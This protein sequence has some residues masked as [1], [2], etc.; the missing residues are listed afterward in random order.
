MM[1]RRP[2]DQRPNFAAETRSRP[3]SGL[4]PL[5]CAP[6]TNSP[7]GVPHEAQTALRPGRP[8][9]V[10]WNR[11]RA[12]LHAVAATRSLEARR[13]RDCTTARSARQFRH[14]DLCP[15]RWVMHPDRNAPCAVSSTILDCGSRTTTLS[16]RFAPLPSD[17]KTGCFAEVTTTQTRPRISSRSS[18]RANC[19]V[20]TQRRTCPTS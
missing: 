1:R 4:Q 9:A 6:R 3:G 17:A 12:D 5:H 10:G 14:A 16:G 18:P 2:A 20:S 15:R 11:V 7:H 8:R 19:M 13:G